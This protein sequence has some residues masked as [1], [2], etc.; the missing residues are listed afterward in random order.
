MLPL[1]MLLCRPAHAGPQAD[2]TFLA[3]GRSAPES[4]IEVPSAWEGEIA[5]AGLVAVDGRL[6]FGDVLG[7]WGRLG[8][9]AW[10]YAP[11]TEAS[12]LDGGAAGGWVSEV[13]NAGLVDLAGRYDLQLYPGLSQAG[14]GRGEALLRGR[15]DG[16]G[17]ELTV[18][19][20]GVDRRFL[21]FASAD[22]SSGELGLVLGVQLAGPLHMDLG[23]AGQANEQGA[24]GND[25]PWGSQARG[26]L[27]LTAAGGKVHGSVDYRFLAAFSGETEQARAPVFTMTG[28]YSDDVDALSGGGF[29]QHRV[30]VGGAAEA[31]PWTVSAGGLLRLRQAGTEE[32]QVAYG[33]SWQGQVR[34][35][36]KLGETLTAFTSTGA[37]A[38]SIASGGYLDIFGWGG[39]EWRPQGKS[40]EQVPER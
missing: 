21:D 1:L 23:A 24:L 17:W 18:Q 4:A 40:A 12:L 14:S 11:E 20:R 26:H 28:D 31:G 10:G 5:P 27:R 7:P 32:E 19:A 13:G 30:D 22:F 29:T 16:R 37:S 38:A 39:L 36:R 34:L 8:L 3:G 2:L 9:G 25:G 15:H 6:R 33:Q 35:D